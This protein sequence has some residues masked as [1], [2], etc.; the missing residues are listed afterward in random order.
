M[1]A[2]GK[3]NTVLR[4]ALI[5]WLA[6]APLFLTAQDTNEGGLFAELSFSEQ[7]VDDDDGTFSRTR[8]D[9]TLSSATKHRAFELSFGGSYELALSG[10]EDDGFDDPRVSLSFQE[11][12]R[13]QRLT[14]DASFRRQ[15]IETSVLTA[16]NLGF[17]VV[18]DEGQQEDFDAR[19][20]YEFGRDLPFGGAVTFAY[21]ERNFVDTI[22]TTLIDSVTVSA[23]ARLEFQLHP[24]AR[25]RVTVFA[26]ELD[27][28]GGV[29]VDT[30]RFGIGATLNLT[31]TLEADVDLSFSS[32]TET[33]VG[34]DSDRDGA[35][36]TL[37]L[38]ET[39]Q[40][41][42]LSGLITTDITENGRVTTLSLGRE[43]ELPRGQLSATLGYTFDENDNERPTFNVSYVEALPRGQFSVSAA[44]SFSV[45]SN[46]DEVV[47]SQLRVGHSQS[48]TERANFNVSASYSTTDFLSG[49]SNDSEQFDLSFSFDQEITPIWSFIAGYSHTRRSSDS[50]TE[51]TDDEIFIGLQS[52]IGWRP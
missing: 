47:N 2:G 51:S 35:A 44:Q 15:D 38:V 12:T 34:A 48:L 30:E 31:P 46:G 8:A 29:D 21:D 50:G 9:F 37:S 13:T 22:S 26:S 3:H 11:E 10:D 1:R 23:D 5:A 20:T 32:V 25:A 40:N 36:F 45:S 39:L 4:A 49:L 28:D 33:G 18:L 27:R 52:T 6:S 41:G 7:L 42:T 17:Q 14:F 43:L 19:L 16:T 24:K